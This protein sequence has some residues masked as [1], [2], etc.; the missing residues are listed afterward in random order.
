MLTLPFTKTL[1]RQAGQP[2]REHDILLYNESQPIKELKTTLWTY[3]QRASDSRTLAYCIK[4]DDKV[5]HCS[6]DL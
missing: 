4:T 1:G 6:R 3:V 5:R 2:I